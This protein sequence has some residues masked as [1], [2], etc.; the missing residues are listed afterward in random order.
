ME[1]ATRTFLSSAPM[2]DKGDIDAANQLFPAMIFRRRKTG[3]V[4]TTCCRKRETR[5]DAR[6]EWFEIY[7]AEH[8]PEPITSMYWMHPKNAPEC[9]RRY[10]CPICGAEAK[11]KELGRCGNGDN[12]YRYRRPVILKW[13]GEALW[14]MAYSA[15]KRYA[16]RC[17]A[18]WLTDDPRMTLIGAYKYQP[19]RVDWTMSSY[20]YPERFGA[21]QAITEPAKGRWRVCKPYT[22]DKEYNGGYDIIGKDAL[23]EGWL[24]YT[25]A[26]R[27]SAD[28]FRLLAVACFYPAQVEWLTKLGLEEAVEVY[29]DQGT[30]NA[31]LIR[32]EAER[33]KDFLPLGIREIRSIEGYE[34]LETIKAWHAAKGGLSLEDAGL[35][36]SRYRA[37]ERKTILSAAKA[38]GVKEQKLMG[39]LEGLAEQ[40]QDKSRR[41]VVQEYADYIRAAKGVGLD[42]KNEIHLM[43]RDFKRKHDEVTDAFA[44]IENARIEAEEEA[45]YRKRRERL[46]RKYGFAYDGLEIVVPSGSKQIVYEGKQLRHCV[47]GY[48]ARHI[49][50][51]V[52]ILF[53]RKQSAMNTPFITIEMWEN[54]IMQA[55]GYNDERT[56]C[57]DNPNALPVTKLHREFFDTWL[58]WLKAGSR[59]NKDGSPKLPEKMEVKSA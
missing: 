30:R 33:P 38:G 59:R 10:R 55:H 43:P 19:G 17:D 34:R 7:H 28:L 52:T 16:P 14:V 23:K 25:G 5:I 3:E 39:Y 48:A 27:V 41:A 24:K 6:P 31:R 26:D 54:K 4:W 37:K 49:A 8:V 46:E 1:D 18:R 44:A 51:S 56:G 22:N 13:Q 20:W 53:L 45:Q 50:G 12:L 40:R 42:L 57:P 32:W 21:V 11:V 47:G 2:L 29:A 58:A 9:D 15:E 35:L 36:V